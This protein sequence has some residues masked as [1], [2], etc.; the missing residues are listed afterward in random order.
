MTVDDLAPML[1][2]ERA[3]FPSPWTAA[4]F[5]QELEVSFSRV[6]V[7]RSVE[8]EA[9]ILGYLCRW[10]VA[11]EVQILNVAVAPHARRRGVAA[12][13]VEEVH[14]EAAALGLVALTLEVR[15]RNTAARALYAA[16]GFGEVGV[17]PDYYARGEDALIMR[18]VLTH[19]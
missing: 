15:C 7:A 3:S 13:M 4:M 2:I 14:R 9:E 1:L 6:I 18:R 10:T 17:R 12:T 16:C 5:L 11:D 19:A 8:S